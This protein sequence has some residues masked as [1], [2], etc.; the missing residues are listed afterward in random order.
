MVL[1]LDDLD[2]RAV[3]DPE[4]SAKVRRQRECPALGHL[5]LVTVLDVPQVRSR[6]EFFSRGVRTT[7]GTTPGHSRMDGIILN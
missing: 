2:R 3:V 7:I 6:H 5:R 4:A 1:F